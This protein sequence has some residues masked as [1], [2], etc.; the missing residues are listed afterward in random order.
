M[1]RD[2]IFYAACGLSLIGTALA[3]LGFEFSVL[4]FVCAYLLRPALNEFG[5]AKQAADE[6]EFMIHSRSGN[7]AFITMVL[8]AVG[9]ALWRIAMGERPEELY[10]IIA[11]GLAVRALTG[12]IMAGDYRKAGSVIIGAEG[13]FLAMFVCME[14]GFSGA[15]AGAAFG[16]LIIG[17]AFFARK[18]PVIAAA[19][20]LCVVILLVLFCNL[21]AFQ[22]SGSALWLFVVSPLMAASACLVLGRG[23]EDNVVSGK[24]RAAVFGTLALCAAAVFAV[25]LIVGSGAHA[26]RNR[27]HQVGLTPGET[28]L[29]QNVPCRGSIETFA[30][31]KLKSCVLAKEDTLLGQLFP[32]GTV[33]NFTRD[34]VFDWCF[35]QQ[36]QVIQGHLCR[37]EAHGFMTCFHPNGRLKLAWLGRDEMIQGIPCSKFTWLG[38][39][40]GGASGVSFHPNGRLKHAKLYREA[41]VEGRPYQKG[42]HMYFDEN[43]KLIKTK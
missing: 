38:D 31:G 35:L 9:F 16:L 27:G 29:V 39:V 10:E 6:R 11:I 36:D 23:K 8:A 15:L 25:L 1:K 4:L 33:V 17:F 18:F 43:G 14:T 42:T 37:G 19:V 24:A 32:A 41:V 3:F 30:N 20:L 13:L 22:P 28:T 40:L 12:L 2:K 5:L 21:I 34:G 7:I 26:R